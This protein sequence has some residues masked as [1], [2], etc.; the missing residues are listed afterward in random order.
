MKRPSSAQPAAAMGSVITDFCA[1]PTG[2][3]VCAAELGPVG[4]AGLASAG[5]HSA[6]TQGFVFFSLRQERSREIG[7]VLGTARLQTDK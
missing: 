2:R 7:G 1:S 5:G 6:G 3:T 4:K